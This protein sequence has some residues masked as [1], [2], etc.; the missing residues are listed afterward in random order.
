MKCLPSTLAL[1][2]LV[3]LVA[4]DPGEKSVTA[5][6]G[7]D[8]EGSASGSGSA[9]ATG[10]DTEDPPGDES[11][12][13]GDYGGTCVENVTQLASTN[14]VGPTGIDPTPVL[15]EAVG[16][17]NGSL[18]WGPDEG[19]VYYDG[20][21]GPTP[22][23]IEISY[24]GGEIR[25]VDAEL[26]QAC[27]HDG[28]CPC[29]DRIEIDVQLRLVS[30]DG[31]FDE[32]WTVAL[33]HQPVNDYF[34]PVGTSINHPFEPDETVGS[35]SRA[36]FHIEDATL[37]EAVLTGQLIDGA[38]AGG[39]GV[40]VS[41]AGPGGG[42]GGFGSI[43]QIAAVTSL[44]ACT[45]LSGN[46]CA[47]AGCTVAPGVPVFGEGAS[48]SCGEDTENFCFGGPLVGESVP[49]FY[50]RP[51]LYEEGYDL[52]Y[53]FDTLVEDPPAPWRLC[54]DAPEVASCGCF[55]GSGECP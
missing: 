11:S 53:A 24:A 30:E 45:G 39:I 23:E 50:T 16:I 36:S 2:A 54:A 20:P 32:T 29:E 34:S 31:L 9:S 51:D 43:G 18:R 28:P 37:D 15:D 46:N 14:D 40:T 13:T 12:G 6:A 41:L 38:F 19:P 26:V 35:L 5:T 48:C 17:Y 25:D 3:A 8:D 22:V 10:G 27:Q 7:L 42:F 52:V 1:A 21:D 44:E 33:S 55:G 47:D 49:T 4:C